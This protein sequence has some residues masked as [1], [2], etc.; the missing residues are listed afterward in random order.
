MFAHLRGSRGGP[1]SRASGL[2]VTLLAILA[3][4]AAGQGLITGADIRGTVRDASG[5]VL[6]TATVVATSLDTGL[7]RNART[8]LEGRY[9][10]MALPPGSYRVSAAFPAFATQV[11]NEIAVLLGQVV[12]VDFDLTPAISESIVVV[13]TTA[14]AEVGRTGVS[15]VIEGDQ[16]NALP[17]NGRNFISFAALTPGVSPTELALPGAETS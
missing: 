4:D 2:I 10:I 9:A 7:T 12:S 5:A 3:T 13:P 17:I 1:V 8:D 16:I 11:R 14:L 15:A 6:Q